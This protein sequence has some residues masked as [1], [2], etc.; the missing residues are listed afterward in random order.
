MEIDIGTLPELGL[1]AI[2]GWWGESGFIFEIEPFHLQLTT[3]DEDLWIRSDSLIDEDEDEYLFPL[4]LL[5][6]EELLLLLLW[7]MVG[8]EDD[9]DDEVVV[10]VVVVLQVRFH[11][12]T[13]DRDWSAFIDELTGWFNGEAEVNA[14]PGMDGVDAV[15]PE[16]V[17]I[18]EDGGEPFKFVLLNGWGR[19]FLCL[20]TE[21]QSVLDEVD[22]D[23]D[24]FEGSPKPNELLRWQVNS[25]E[26][27]LL[28][29]LGTEESKGW[30]EEAATATAA[31][32]EA[33]PW[34]IK[35]V[36]ELAPDDER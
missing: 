29:S 2:D 28:F 27:L 32:A 33:L 11:I 18:E 35:P 4:L 13:L 9:E 22:E 20:I 24:E 34:P 17:S 3:G 31:I 21:M 16:P 19:L 36:D 14:E 10:V 1:T 7:L 23:E 8:D 12:K 30:M 26:S 6:L 15:E 25:G 5:L